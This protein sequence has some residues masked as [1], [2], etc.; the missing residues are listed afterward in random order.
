M[1]LKLRVCLRVPWK[2]I[3]FVW[4][5]LLMRRINVIDLIIYHQTNNTIIWGSNIQKGWTSHWWI[6][7]WKFRRATMWSLTLTDTHLFFM[8]STTPKKIMTKRRMPAMT[9]A[10]LTVWSVCFS[11]STASG[12][13]VAD[14][15]KNIYKSFKNLKSRSPKERQEKN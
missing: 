9:P 12:L 7:V 13:W 15:R 3:N 14:P 2:R 4:R 1:S 5:V 11:G 10:I 8:R 6:P